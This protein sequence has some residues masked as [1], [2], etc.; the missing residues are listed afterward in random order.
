MK[1][2]CKWYQ[3]CPMKYFTDIGLLN[4]K[5]VNQFCKKDWRSC[6]R[7]QMEEIGI[8]HSDNT[9]PNGEIDHSLPE[10]RFKMS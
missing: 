5:W 8:Y 7:Y 9:L 3:I 10:N 1:T 6:K 4:P 2:I